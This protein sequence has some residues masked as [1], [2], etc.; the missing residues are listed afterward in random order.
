VAIVLIWA[1]FV[2]CQCIQET[3]PGLRDDRDMRVVEHRV[4]ES[5]GTGT[6]RCTPGG[7]VA[8]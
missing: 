5:D 1:G 6:E 7:T 3:H 8:Q 2:E 4:D